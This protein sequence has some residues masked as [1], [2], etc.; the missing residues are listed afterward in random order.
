MTSSI[1]GDRTVLPAHPTL[2]C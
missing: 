1:S 2:I